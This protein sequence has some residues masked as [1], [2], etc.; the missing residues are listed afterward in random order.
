NKYRVSISWNRY[1]KNWNEIG[2]V[3]IDL[4]GLPGDKFHTAICEQS[5]DFYFKE[6]SDAVW[7]S[8]TVE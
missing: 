6:E 8:L 4:F 1:N 5:M 3:A 7:F 2:A